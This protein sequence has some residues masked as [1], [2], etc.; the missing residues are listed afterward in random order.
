MV[1]LSENK[2]SLKIICHNNIHKSTMSL[3]AQKAQ[4]MK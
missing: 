4:L 3:M 1:V 2:I